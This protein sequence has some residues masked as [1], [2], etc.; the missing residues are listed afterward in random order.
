MGRRGWTVP[1][2]LALGVEAAVPRRAGWHLQARNR[3]W[4]VFSLAPL[5]P[6]KTTPPYE[7]LRTIITALT[8]RGAA[9]GVRSGQC[10]PSMATLI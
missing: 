6:L 1:G 3:P 2:L 7:V 10:I 9:K 8:G 4:A 5:G